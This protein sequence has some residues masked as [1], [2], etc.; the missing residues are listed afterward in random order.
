MSVWGYKYRLQCLYVLYVRDVFVMCL[1]V[2]LPGSGHTTRILWE[3]KIYTI[4]VLLPVSVNNPFRMGSLCLRYP[5]G[6]PLP[7]Y[8][9][10]PPWP[11]IGSPWHETDLDT[12]GFNMWGWGQ[13]H[14]WTVPP[15]AS[16]LFNGIHLNPEPDLPLTLK[17]AIDYIPRYPDQNHFFPPIDITVLM[18]IISW[19]D[20][21]TICEVLP[22]FLCTIFFNP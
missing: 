1:L 21:T 7:S 18:P 6:I 14:P 3:L 16:P 8:S 17:Y 12:P 4:A 22:V 20:L 10:L 9:L 19:Y 5:P 11:I 15:I 2:L 13:S